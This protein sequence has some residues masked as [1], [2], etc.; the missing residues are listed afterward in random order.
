[1]AQVGSMALLAARM[2]PRLERQTSRDE[3]TTKRSDND[4]LDM[5][6]PKNAHPNIP[7]AAA[8]HKQKQELHCVY[9]DSQAIG[10]SR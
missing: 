6:R 2:R 8:S 10:A 1:M 5:V 7:V 9:V 4:F 3:S